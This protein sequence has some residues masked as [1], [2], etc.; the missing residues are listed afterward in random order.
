[1][2]PGAVGLTEYARTQRLRLRPRLRARAP[3]MLASIAFIRARV[4]GKSRAGFEACA[5]RI[6]RRIRG[7]AATYSRTKSPIDITSLLL[8]GPCPLLWRR[9]LLFL[10]LGASAGFLLDV[11]GDFVP[12]RDF[13]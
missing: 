4:R 10:D 7:S 8:A 6:W 12:G 13:V 2:P 11:G 5:L 1:M 3:L 9:R